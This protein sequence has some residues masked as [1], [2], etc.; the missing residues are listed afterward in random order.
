ML[1]W[2]GCVFFFLGGIDFFFF[3]SLVSPELYIF[4]SIGFDN[5]KIVVFL[6]EIT[7]AMHRL[8]WD[9][10]LD[11]WCQLWSLFHFVGFFFVC[12][13]LSTAA[14]FSVAAGLYRNVEC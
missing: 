9:R 13:A 4:V 11:S 12:F 8:L 10:E 6:F 3:L 2:L 14:S 5:L 1:L 7:V